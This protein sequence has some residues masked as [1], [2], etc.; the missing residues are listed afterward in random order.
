MRVWFLAALVVLFT[1]SVRAAERFGVPQLPESPFDDTE[2]STNIAFSAGDASV[3]TFSLSLALDASPSN[4]VQLA[5]GMDADSDGVLSWA[6]T[7]FLLGWRCGG[8]FFRDKVTS[9]EAFVAREAG[10]RTLDWALTVGPDQVPRSLTA[11]EGSLGLG[12]A[13]SRGMF[14]PSWNRVRVTLRGLPGPIY[15]AN[16]GVFAPGFA[17]RLR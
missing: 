2:I 6:E 7:D 10:P 5:F 3:R 16:G 9:T 14:D 12:F 4:T 17:I 8:W 1:V 13:A 15:A 11:K